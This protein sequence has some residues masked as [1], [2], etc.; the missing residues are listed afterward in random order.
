MAIKATYVTV[1]GEG[2]E[3]QKDPVTDNGS[4]KSATGLLK[5][6][7]EDGKYVLV[8]KVPV[9]EEKEG[10]L[11]TVFLDGNLVRQQ[12]LKDIRERVSAKTAKS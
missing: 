1:D 8:D 2:R 9:E 7:K 6:V 10:E 11:Q 12:Y 4:K 5:V 3:I